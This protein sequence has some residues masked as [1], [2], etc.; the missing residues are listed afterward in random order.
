[1]SFSS[2]NSFQGVLA[3]VVALLSIL[4][5]LIVLKEGIGLQSL[6][7]PSLELVASYKGFSNST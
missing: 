7:V 4:A 6:P 5:Y 3:V 2:R 1:M